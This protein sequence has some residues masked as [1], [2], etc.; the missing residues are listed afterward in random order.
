MVW[1][2]ALG[3][4]CL[5]AII[6]FVLGRRGNPKPLAL[7]EAEFVPM[8]R[9]VH[10]VRAEM[11]LAEEEEEQEEAYEPPAA[12]DT[13]VDEV[14]ELSPPDYGDS[15]K[16]ISVRAAPVASQ[17]PMDKPT[18]EFQAADPHEEIT[19]QGANEIASLARATFGAAAGGG[20]VDESTSFYQPDTQTLDRLRE[21]AANVEAAHSSTI[22]ERPAVRS[23]SVYI[24]S[25][26]QI[27]ERV[28]SRRPPAAPDGVFQDA[29]SSGFAPS[30]S[31]QSG[32][33]SVS[34][35]ATPKVA[36]K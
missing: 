12:P 4:A 14:E 10:S 23:E 26:V 2:L 27:E 22:Q 11:A 32:T 33:R 17:P 30:N 6:G 25:N 24:Q 5:A 28:V 16:V 19:A 31:L 34:P 18:V 8:P 7:P 3:A 15:S 21:M 1:V 29:R 13:M 20:E 9:P 36:R 35:S